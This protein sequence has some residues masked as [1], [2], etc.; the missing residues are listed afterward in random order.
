M[1]APSSWSSVTKRPKVRDTVSVAAY[2]FGIEYAKGSGAVPYHSEACRDA[3]IIIGREGDKW[4]LHFED[5]K[6][7]AFSRKDIWLLSRPAAAPGA[8]RST[9]VEVAADCDADSL[10]MC[11][12]FFSSGRVVRGAATLM[13]HLLPSLPHSLPPSLP[14]SL[15]PTHPPLPPSLP[16]LPY[17]PYLA[18]QLY[19]VTLSPPATT[20][21]PTARP[22]QPPLPRRCLTTV[23]PRTSSWQII[24]DSWFGS[25]ACAI[26][27][28]EKG[29]FC[30][31]NVK[32][33]HTGYPKNEMLEVVAEIKGTQPGKEVPI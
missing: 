10:R 11:V 1:A 16:S 18:E 6:E 30:V 22:A 17:L 27:L 19:A 20:T 3:G 32:T 13:G 9:A 23:P 21:C 28:F 25:K 7:K 26:A 33:A 5:G 2:H 14:L 15:P 24:A 8:A 12:P 4:M 31:M 29:L